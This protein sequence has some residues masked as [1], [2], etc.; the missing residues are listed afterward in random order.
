VLRLLG[1]V[2]MEQDEAWTTGHRYFDMHPYWQWRAE[3]EAGQPDTVASTRRRNT[4][5]A[6]SSRQE[7]KCERQPGE[8]RCSARCAG[9]RCPS[10]C[11]QEER[12]SCAAPRV[13]CACR[14][15][16]RGGSSS[17][18]PPSSLAR[19]SRRNRSTTHS[20]TVGYAGTVQAMARA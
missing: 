15:R 7:K 16:C 6:V 9:R 12:A 4:P 19:P 1:A 18:L 13:P 20:S 11:P 8:K 3:L 10:R 2:L 5:P 17:A 14:A